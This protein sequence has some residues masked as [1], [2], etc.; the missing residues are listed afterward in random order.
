LSKVGANGGSD[1]RFSGPA[2]FLR[3]RIREESGAKDKA[4]ACFR[5]FRDA[6]PSSPH[7]QRAL[8]ALIRL[9]WSSK[10]CKGALGLI[11]DYMALYPEDAFAKE[12]RR[13]SGS[14]TR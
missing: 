13:L 10:G 12:A 2:H 4:M 3:C 6:F 1:R 11:S 14:C 5:A 9:S 7:D 8:Q